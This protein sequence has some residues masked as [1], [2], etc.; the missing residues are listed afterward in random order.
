MEFLVVDTETERHRHDPVG[1]RRIREVRGV[2]GSFEFE[3]RRQR[4]EAECVQVAQPFSVL[5]RRVDLY[6]VTE[7]GQPGEQRTPD[8]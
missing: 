3:A 8:R 4:R 1:P 2:A 6:V 5:R 7:V